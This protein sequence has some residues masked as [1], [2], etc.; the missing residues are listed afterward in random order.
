M[1]TLT[2]YGAKYNRNILFLE[3]LSTDTKPTG[4]FDGLSIQN[5]SEYTEVDTGK[6]FLFDYD[7]A[8]WYEV[9]TGGGGGGGGGTSNYN[10]LSNRPSVNNTVLT[11]NKTSAQLGLASSEQGGKADSALQGVK[12]NSG[13][14]IT[15]DANNIVDITVGKS[16]VGLGN[17]TNDAQVKKISSSTSGDIVTWSGTSGDTVADSGI[18]IETSITDSNLKIPTS[19][20]VNTALSAKANAD[21]VYKLALSDTDLLP[22][23]TD[24]DNIKTVGC[25][26]VLAA[27]T[28]STI[29]HRPANGGAFRL[30]VEIAAGTMRPRQIYQEFNS[31]DK[32][33][34]YETSSGTWAD[35]KKV[36]CDLSTKQNT[37]SDLATIRSGAAL[38]AT[39]VQPETG[40]GLSTN[41][42]TTAEKTK[43][44]GIEAQANKTTV[45]DALSG[46]STN[47]VQNKVVK[48]ALDSKA[49]ASSTYTKTEVDT[50]LSGK[51]ATLTTA[52]LAAANS[53]ITS[54]DVAQIT[55]NKNNIKLVA[56]D[57]TVYN[58]IDSI[59]V[60][61]IKSLNL[62]GTWTDNVY[63]YANIKMIV[64]SDGT[65]TVQ[66]TQSSSDG[67][68][69]SFKVPTL[70]NDDYILLGCPAGG[71]GAATN[72]YFL[73][74]EYERNGTTYY[75]LD[76]G[77]GV[78]FDKAN[79]DVIHTIRIGVRPSTNIATPITFKPQI[80]SK[81]LY[82]RGFTDFQPYAM[83]NAELTSN[84]QWNINNGVKNLINLPD[85]TLTVSGYDVVQS[86]IT[87]PAGTYTF[88][89]TA[90]SIAAMSLVLYDSSTTEVG[91]LVIDNVTNG[92][93]H[94]DFTIPSTASKASIWI[95]LV[96]GASSATISNHMIC[97]KSVYDTD[98]TYRPY[99]MSNAELTAAIQAL[100]AQLANQ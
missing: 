11:G 71:S 48:T 59:N 96:D 66:T 75:K 19:K 55:T 35:W 85:K 50:A 3:G 65:V 78:V 61:V 34:R 90:S 46:S 10:D 6:K 77:D 1:V 82:D 49:D 63:T 84:T 79:N 37:I 45:D 43:L 62:N 8:T 27:A 42:Y 86:P 94:G 99:A 51:Q 21:N 98:S 30:T 89:F 23:N 2:K 38:G 29:I 91:R 12:L 14:V 4:E 93:N 17:V 69:L 58:Y 60:P 87:L 88:S 54:A 13:S 80:I 20:A 81:S 25:Y 52:Q 95:N 83:S 97:L 22:A 68:G 5:G 74:Y 15:P 9:Q 7:N 47:P 57:S 53:G 92:E 64:N 32:Y 28:V 36:E 100:Q 26:Y 76:T 41:D 24:L 16:D 31:Y 56:N 70:P 40:K 18:S 39:A 33:I 44:A 72:G 73:L 67:L